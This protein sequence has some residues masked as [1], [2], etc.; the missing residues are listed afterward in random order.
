MKAPPRPNIRELLLAKFEALLD[1]R[2]LVADNAAYGQP[3]T[4]WMNSSSSKDENSSRKPSMRSFP[5]FVGY[6]VNKMATY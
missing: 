1:E 5:A 4:T 2:D 6:S 3:S